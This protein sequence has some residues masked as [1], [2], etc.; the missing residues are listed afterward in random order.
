MPDF[1]LYQYRVQ[2]GRERC[3]TPF[4]KRFMVSDRQI[5]ANRLNARFSTG[6]KTVEGKAQSSR[7]AVTHGLTAYSGLLGAESPKEF[8]EMRESVLDE[9]VPEGAIESELAD[10]II[11][12]LW[13]LRRIPAFEA[14]VLAWVQARERSQSTYSVGNPRLAGDPTAPLAT[15]Y[16]DIQLVL[17][18]SLDAF[19]TK[20][21][22]GKL[23]RY[24]TTLQRQLS[25]LL[26]ELRKMQA[27]R[28]EAA[29]SRDRLH[30]L[31]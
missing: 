12:I 24:E 17:G 30:V 4:K 19:L 6:P 13:R 14:A 28:Q 1:V 16:K 26:S 2:A 8:F 31:E 7:N 27:R 29:Q 22:G 20:D 9:L 15:D 21:L 10:R 5:T 3:R 18:R 11:S 23:G 25:A